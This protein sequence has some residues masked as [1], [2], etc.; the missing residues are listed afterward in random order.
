MFEK[1]GVTAQ[2]KTVTK[3]WRRGT[4]DQPELLLARD[5]LKPLVEEHLLSTLLRGDWQHGVI[6]QVGVAAQL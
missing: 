6:P 1:S 5:A 2:R 4:D 3:H